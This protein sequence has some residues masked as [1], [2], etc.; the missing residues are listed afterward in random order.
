MVHVEIA[1]SDGSMF[2]LFSFAT[3]YRVFGVILI[4]GVFYAMGI[5]VCVYLSR[6]CFQG[7]GKHGIFIIFFFIDLREE[8]G[9]RDKNISNKNH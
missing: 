2:F 5:C 4:S 7:F 3:F 1:H 8:E 6:V 9:E